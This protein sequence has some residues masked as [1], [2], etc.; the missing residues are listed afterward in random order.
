MVKAFL[1]FFLFFIHVHTKEEIGK[2]RTNDFRLI[3]CGTQSI[4]LP[5]KDVKAFLVDMLVKGYSNL[6]YEKKLRPLRNSIYF[7]GFLK[8]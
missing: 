4:K 7:P 5:L 6:Q 2:I 8:I 1:S 3:M